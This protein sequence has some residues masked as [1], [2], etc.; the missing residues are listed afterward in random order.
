MRDDWRYVV[1]RV[2]RVSSQSHQYTSH[3]DTAVY[4]STVDI[5]HLLGSSTTE[6]GE[7][8]IQTEP[9]VMSLLEVVWSYSDWILVAVLLMTAIYTLGTWN[10]DY[11]SRQN[12]PYVKPI[13]FLGNMA[14][15]F[16]GKTSNTHNVY[17]LYRSH[18]GQR[19]TGTFH[20]GQPSAYI[21]DPELIKTIMIKDFDHF[22]D[23]H[24]GVSPDPDQLFT[25]TLILLRGWCS[26][27]DPL[28]FKLMVEYL[29]SYTS[30][31]LHKKK[32]TQCSNQ[33]R[34][35]VPGLLSQPW[36]YPQLYEFCSGQR[37]REMRT[38]L[39]QTF[40]S[41][42]MKNMFGLV[43]HCGQQMAEFLEGKLSK[44]GK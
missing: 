21:N 18:R 15:V 13:P 3:H 20:Y 41:S 28:S 34:G 44:Q 12:I 35:T 9:A 30:Q 31:R 6:D 4:Q 37:W 16:F 36:P 2:V 7:I 38:L 42:K 10:H 5:S 25:E 29:Q 8:E 39:T 1:T 11:F 22:T 14:P 19:V 17:R 40:T 33:W 43:L 24:F 32:A 26:L 23:H 27:H